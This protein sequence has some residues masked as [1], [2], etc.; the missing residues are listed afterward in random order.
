MRYL[1]DSDGNHIANEVDGQLHAPS[2]ENIGHFLPDEGFFI[3]MNGR[4]LGEIVYDNRLMANTMSPYEAVDFGV[5]GD[6]G[7]VGDYGNPGN[8]G[9]IGLVSGYEDIPGERL[10]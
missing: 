5:Y 7:N 9:S 8:Y 2:G 4:Y 10:G 6:Y 3:D 1:F